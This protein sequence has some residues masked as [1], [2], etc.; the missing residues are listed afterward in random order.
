MRAILSRLFILFTI[1]M[2]PTAALAHSGHGDAGGF[3][4]GFVHPV[5]GIDHVLAMVTVGLLAYQLGGRALWLVP[6]TFVLVMAL[7]GTLGIAGIPVPLVEIA[8]ALS[9]VVLGAVVALN[10]RTPVALAMGIVGLFAIFHGYA[11]GAEMPADASGASYALGFM[12]ATALLHAAGI[13]LGTGIG[14]ITQ[15]HGKAAFR[16]AGAL[17]AVAGVAL[18]T[19]A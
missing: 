9:V 8:I 15:A 13:G 4:D 5:G 18:L 19:I 3:V 12:V 11:H 10:L 16:I 6:A 1:L 17:V 7:G 14:V 2:L